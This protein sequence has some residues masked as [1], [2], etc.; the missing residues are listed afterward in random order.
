PLSD[1]LSI[2]N[3][4][5]EPTKLFKDCLGNNHLVCKDV[6]YQLYYDS[7]LHF[8]PP[9]S[10][11]DFETILLPCVTQDSLNLYTVEKYGAHPIDIGF[12]VFNTNNHGLAYFFI[13]KRNRIKND[14]IYIEDE[15]IIKM[16]NDEAR[17]E[18]SK[19][20]AG[21]YKHGSPEQDRLFAETVIF[22]EIYAPLFK[23]DRNVYVFDYINGNIQCFSSGKFVNTT[24]ITFQKEKHWKK[25][26]YIDE[27]RHKAYSV[28]EKNGIVEAREVNLSSGMLG[29]GI[30]IPFVFIQNIKIRDGYIYF[31]YK[32]KEY[33]DTRYLSRF[34][35]E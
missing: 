14:L 9:K 7:S 24:A 4:P 25:E 13:N 8:L 28:F 5:V 6:I 3:L 11:N 22:K 32:E 30:K 15:E 1:T 19:Q 10:I 23:I 18:R 17:Y 31:L 35:I 34:R 20:A 12:R 21:L 27:K 16:S 26:M 2:V 29:S 33:Q